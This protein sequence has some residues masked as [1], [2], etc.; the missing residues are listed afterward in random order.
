MN[1]IKF[2]DKHPKE[3]ESVLVTD[4]KIIGCAYIEYY[5]KNNGYF[6]LYGAAHFGEEWE[7]IWGKNERVTHWMPLPE[8][9]K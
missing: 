9:P 5:G 8:L 1:W 3:G 2:S 7:W 6:Y 4:G